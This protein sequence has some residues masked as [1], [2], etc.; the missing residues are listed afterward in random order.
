ML[1]Y[2]PKCHIGY[3]V[4]D[5]LIPQ[6]GRKVRCSSCGEIFYFD[7]TGDSHLVSEEAPQNEETTSDSQKTIEQQETPPVASKEQEEDTSVD[8]SDIYERLSAQSEHLFQE[9]QKLP[10]KQ[11]ILLILKTILGLNRKLNFKLIGGVFAIFVCL[12]LYNY[13][14]E[15]VD[16]VPFTNYIYRIFGITAQ[17][18]GKGLEFQNINWNYIENEG[19][20]L[21]E[22]KGFIG[23]TTTREIDIPT[24][25]VELLDKNTMLLQSFNQKPSVQSLK[26]DGRIGIGIIIK[27][28]SISAKYVHLTF[29][30]TD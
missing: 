25:H 15:I 13:R 27:T 1:I 5:Q 11:R 24:V 20:R 18:P 22:I 6:S 7:K 23:N 3:N 28:P 26:P 16:T 4:D 9:E 21:L 19:S 17:V 2:C 12:M 8:I 14:Y 10:P 30:E 29:I